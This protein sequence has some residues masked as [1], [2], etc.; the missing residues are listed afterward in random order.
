MV[1]GNLNKMGNCTET[2]PYEKLAKKEEEKAIKEWKL[3]SQKKLFWN[4]LKP[5]AYKKGKAD[6]ET[7]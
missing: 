3:Q 7:P 5:R 1:F 6:K 2:I 4:F